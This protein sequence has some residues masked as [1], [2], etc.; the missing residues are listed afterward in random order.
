MSPIDFVDPQHHFSDDERQRLDRIEAELEHGIRELQ[1]IG[2]AVTV[3]GSAR[4]SVQSWEYV[5]AYA[6]GKALAE[7]GVGV[8][9]GGGPGVMEAANRGALEAGGL[10]VGLNITLPKEQHPNPYL[11]MGLEF[12]YFFTR[13]FLLILYALGFVAFPGGFG[14]TDELFELLTLMQTGKLDK[15][16][17]ILVGTEFFEPLLQ[18][19]RDQM[20]RQHYI[21][22]LDLDLITL[23]DDLDEVI[24]RLFCCPRLSKA[25]G[26]NS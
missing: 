16:P 1:S 10:S 26:H 13:K 17:I 18:F 3:F 12:R 5:S 21:G 23:T 4:S 19:V 9:T 15:R 2:P 11:S 22:P 14:T 25:V 6:L 20:V 24:T 8:I 7:R